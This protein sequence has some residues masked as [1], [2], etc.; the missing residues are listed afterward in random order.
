MVIRV[1]DIAKGAVGKENVYIATEDDRIAKVVDAYD[2]KVWLKNQNQEKNDMKR[3]LTF[4]FPLFLFAQEADIPDNIQ[5]TITQAKDYYDV[6]L[7]EEAKTIL[8]ILA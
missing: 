2:Y 6:S 8:L 1:A 3:L 7:F 5:K 4:I